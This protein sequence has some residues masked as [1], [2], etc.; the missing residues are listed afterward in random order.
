MD[1]MQMLMGMDGVLVP[2]FSAI[3][4]DKAT[5]ERSYFV[6]GQSPLGGRTTLRCVTRDGAN[7]NLG[8]GPAVE[9][10]AFLDCIRLFLAARG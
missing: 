5:D 10:E 8:S 1:P 9:K 2:Y 7:C 6:L 4:R 3:V